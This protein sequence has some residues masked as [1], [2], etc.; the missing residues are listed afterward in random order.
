MVSVV[1]SAWNRT[2]VRIGRT[3]S[4]DAARATRSI[5]SASG[6]AGSFAPSAV[7]LGQAGKVLGRQR[8]Q[9]K[10]RAARRQLDVALLRLASAR[11]TSPLGR[12]RT[13]SPSRRPGSSSVPSVSTV[14]LGELHRQAELRIGG[15]EDEFVRAGGR[16]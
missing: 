14:R 10:A 9:V 12:L 13:T 8:P 4:R 3:S 15:G 1:P 5:V 16:A 11:L 7:E 2:P 6:P